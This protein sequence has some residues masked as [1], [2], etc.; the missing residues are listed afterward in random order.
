MHERCC[1]QSYGECGL[2]RPILNG[3]VWFDAET[4][5]N[6]SLEWE[7]SSELSVVDLRRTP[8]RDVLVVKILEYDS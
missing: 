6:D 7:R 1:R 8:E 2:P 3:H 4:K 5:F